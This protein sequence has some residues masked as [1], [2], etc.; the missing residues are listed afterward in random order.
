MVRMPTF[1]P[2]GG[3]VRVVFGPVMNLDL[4]LQIHERGID[5]VVT[6]A[7]TADTCCSAQVLPAL[8]P[9]PLALVGVV[10]VFFE[11]RVV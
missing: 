7:V 2:A 9:F 10:Q 8:L 5:V 4:V 1:L 11:G 3:Q 6:P